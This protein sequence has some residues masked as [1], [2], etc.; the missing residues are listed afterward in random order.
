MPTQEASVQ[1]QYREEELRIRIRAARKR[2][3]SLSEERIRLL[4]AAL[5]FGIASDGDM[6]DSLLKQRAA[7][8]EL[9]L[10]VREYEAFLKSEF[11]KCSTG[12]S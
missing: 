4:S 5:H 7:A 8:E 1:R 6:T 9:S 12:S 10:A 3:V 2:F 11:T